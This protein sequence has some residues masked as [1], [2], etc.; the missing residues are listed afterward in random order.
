[1]KTTSKMKM[2]SSMKTNEDELNYYNYYLNFFE[3]LLP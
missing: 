2:T 1:M 3:D